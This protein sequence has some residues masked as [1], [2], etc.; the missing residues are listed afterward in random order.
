MIRLPLHMHSLIVATLSAQK[1]DGAFRYD[2]ISADNRA[3]S[4]ALIS[5]YRRALLDLQPSAMRIVR[6]ALCKAA[7]SL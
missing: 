4:L 2:A 6:Y 7:R 5:P 3:T 1:L